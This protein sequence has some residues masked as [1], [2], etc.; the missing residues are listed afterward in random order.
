M[1]PEREIGAPYVV[2][3]A[4][5]IRTAFGEADPPAGWPDFYEHFP[6]AGGLLRVSPVTF[7]GARTLAVVYMQVLWGPMGGEGA[8]LVFLKIDGAWTRMD[9]GCRW[10]A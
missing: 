8:V 5:E 9:S 3:P 10:V 6:G 1:L 4:S 7:N 2:V